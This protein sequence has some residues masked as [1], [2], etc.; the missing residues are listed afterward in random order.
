MADS[1]NIDFEKLVVAWE[2]EDLL[3][4]MGWGDYHKKDAR[5]RTLSRIQ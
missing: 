3:N 2:E 4:I 1:S 5:H